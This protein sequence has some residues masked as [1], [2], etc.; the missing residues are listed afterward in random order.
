MTILPETGSKTVQT[1]GGFASE[2][3]SIRLF[4]ASDVKRKLVEWKLREKVACWRVGECECEERRNGSRMGLRMVGE[5]K[6]LWRES[7]RRAFISEICM[8][9]KKKKKKE[10]TKTKTLDRQ[11]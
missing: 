8:K 10:T 7:D 5:R 9:K 11:L 3:G 4:G 6:C 1:L 2:L